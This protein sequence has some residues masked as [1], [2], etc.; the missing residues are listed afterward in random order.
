MVLPIKLQLIAFVPEPWVQAACAV[1]LGDAQVPVHAV[2]V[3]AE[4]VRAEHDAD[5]D[6]I[7]PVLILA[8]IDPQTAALK[9]VP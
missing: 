1:P 3:P 6:H 8:P 4:Q 5:P 2:H 7:Q 9:F